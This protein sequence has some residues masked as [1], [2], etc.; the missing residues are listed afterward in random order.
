MLFFHYK[1][2]GRLAADITFQDFG[3]GVKDRNGTAI[4]DKNAIATFVDGSDKSIFPRVRKSVFFGTLGEKLEVGK[5]WKTIWARVEIDVKP[6][7]E[8]LDKKRGKEGNGKRYRAGC[9]H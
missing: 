7:N 8:I 4:H 5:V 6:A 3:I 9:F 2:T 1:L